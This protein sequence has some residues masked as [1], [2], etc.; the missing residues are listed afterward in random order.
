MYKIKRIDIGSVAIYSFIMFLILGL[1]VFLPLG[2]LFSMISSFVPQSDE[3]SPFVF[4]IFSGVFLL[5]IPIF[6]AVFGTIAN[7]IIA[8]VYN[9]ISLKFGGV[10]IELDKVEI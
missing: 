1:I 7:V 5:L 3:F 4:P 8:A 9:L 2:L 6:Y 10:K